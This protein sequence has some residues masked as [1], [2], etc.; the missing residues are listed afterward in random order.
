M[1]IKVPCRGDSRI[2]RFSNG[3]FL[4]SELKPRWFRMP[5]MGDS[6]IAPTDNEN[7]FWYFEI[8]WSLTSLHWRTTWVKKLIFV[9]LV[10]Q[11]I[12]PGVSKG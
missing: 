8:D 10:K 1:H 4:S 11:D 2:A 6:W 5:D 7:V 3:Y 9:W 12:D